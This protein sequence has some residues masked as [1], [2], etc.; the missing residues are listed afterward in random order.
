MKNNKIDF[1]NVLAGLGLGFLVLFLVATVLL[2]TYP[3]SDLTALFLGRTEIVEDDIDPFL[4]KKI[5]GDGSTNPQETIEDN[6]DP[7]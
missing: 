1:K 2:K 7:F 4:K 3:D 5:N 6:I